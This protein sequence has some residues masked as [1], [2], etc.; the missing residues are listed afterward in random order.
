MHNKLDS[1][2]QTFTTDKKNINT[3]DEIKYEFEI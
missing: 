1:N 2:K 3:N